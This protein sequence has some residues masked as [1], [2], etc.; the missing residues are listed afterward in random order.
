MSSDPGAPDDKEGNVPQ[1]AKKPFCQ[2]HTCAHMLYWQ[3]ASK[4]M[5]SWKQREGGEVKRLLG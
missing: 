4:G 5:T 3:L 2:I 1:T